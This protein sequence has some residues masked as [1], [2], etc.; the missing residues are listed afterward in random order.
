MTP[1]DRRHFV[2]LTLGAALSSAAMA[3]A[4]MVTH[5]VTPEDGSLRLDLAAYPDLTVGGGALRLQPAG[6]ADPVFVLALPDGEYA[7]LSPICTHRGCTV[8][9]A[10]DALVCPCHGSTYD[11]QG[12]VLEGPAE[13]P[14]HRFDTR[15]DS[16]GVL[17]VRL[18]P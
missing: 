17:H 16:D 4:S 6:Y 5:R 18:E 10:G 8:D 14:L 12:S 1:M 9:V 7:A 2:E 11:R 13:R 15:L 3:C